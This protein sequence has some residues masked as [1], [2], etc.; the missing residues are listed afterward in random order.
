M[1]GD[2]STRKCLGFHG[3]RCGSELTPDRR[4]LCRE[5]DARVAARQRD[6]A[7]PGERRNE[8]QWWHRR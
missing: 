6:Y 3:Y 2:T 8:E 1:N 4:F 7:P 5:C